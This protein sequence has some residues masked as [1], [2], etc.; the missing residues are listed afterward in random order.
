[1]R[2]VLGIIASAAFT[3][4]LLAACTGGARQD[5][6]PRSDPPE[7]YAAET[8]ATQRARL[9][10]LEAAAFSAPPLP[11]EP[12]SA[13]VYAPFDDNGVRLAATDPVSTFSIDVD[14]GSYANVRRWL[15]QGRL[16]PEDAVRVEEMINYFDYAYARPRDRGRPFS[17]STTLS[18]APWNADAHLLRLAIQG[19]DI[20]AR[21]RPPANLV[22]LVDV[23]GSMNAPDKL[24][25]LKRGLALLVD[26]M[27]AND[28]L[29]LVVYA[30]ASGIVLE[31]TPGDRKA[32]IRAAIEALQ[33]GGMTNGASGIRLAYELARQAFIADGINR[34][35]LATDG[36][37]NVGTV[38][39]EELIDLVERGRDSGVALTTLGFGSGNYND[40]LMEQLADKGN[41]NHAYI[42]TLN[43]ARKVLVEEMSSTLLTI[44]ADVKAQIEFNPA[45]VAEYRLI[46]YENRLL[47][48]ED[49]NND[50]VDAGD[51][52]AGHSV[53]VLYEIA[54]TDSAARRVDAL[55][56]QPAAAPP[57]MQDELAWLKLRYKLPGETAS[58]L[59][60]QAIRRDSEVALAATDDDFRFAAAVAA[61]SQKLRG[62]RYLGG[63]DYGAIRELAAD[64]RGRDAH[65]YR[66]EFQRLVGLAESLQPR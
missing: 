31:P 6:S 13:E 33:P 16:P 50:K 52:G 64:A 19:Y 7:T 60:E 56:Y 11:Q 24:P 12:L 35:I 42:D 38:N 17:V 47:M 53:T 36:D 37:F 63:F 14:T 59:I 28:R 27:T 32:E 26:R 45:V 9:A 18:R 4:A 55:R 22:F 21:E 30:G 43:E 46:G 8:H 44:A 23:S 39:F 20:D 3:T 58:R 15:N 1:M 54:L 29:S 34:V 62:G 10:A 2:K 66:G 5:A 65:G 25:L 57:G 41:G 48:Q 61:F 49:F 51:I 40:R